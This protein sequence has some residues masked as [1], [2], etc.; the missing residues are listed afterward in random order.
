MSD[1]TVLVTGASGFVGGHMVHFLHEKGVRVKA[2]VRDEE[3]NVSLRNLRGVELVTADLRDSNSLKRAVD[4]VTHIYNI[5]SLFRRAGLYEDIFFD[6]NVNGVKRLFEAAIEAGVQRIVHCS[7]V[8]VLG[9]VKNPPATENTECNPGDVYQRT[10][11]EGEKIAMDFYRS[12][13]MRGVVIRPAMVYGP[14]DTRNQK[15]FKMIA[16]RCFFYVGKGDAYVHFIHV[17]DL[18][19]AFFLA[20]NKC[21]LN[22]ET[23]IISGERAVPLYEMVNVIADTLHVRRPWLHLPVK[24]MQC[25]G[26]IC[27]AICMPLHIEPP[28]FRR[29]VDFFTKNRHFDSSKA[30]RDL[31]FEPQ[32][33]F[34]QELIDI[35][36]WYRKAGWL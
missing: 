13:K 32:N 24:P 23:Y 25:L 15:L 35:I 28:I 34:K 7:T 8:G 36:D 9:D 21:D 1:I 33:N 16:K 14:G 20:M 17:S 5:A 18:V 6:I 30:K 19:R 26:S 10:K 29:R 31:G 27:E 12:G 22:A 3:K 11:L 4:G 2:M